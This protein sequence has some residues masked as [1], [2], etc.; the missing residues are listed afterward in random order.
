MLSQ[1]ARLVA[2]ESKREALLAATTAVEFLEAM[3]D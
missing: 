1:I 3:G 2:D